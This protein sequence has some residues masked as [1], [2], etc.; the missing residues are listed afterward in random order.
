MLLLRRLPFIWLKDAGVMSSWMPFVVL[1]AMPSSLPSPVKEVSVAGV[2][3][4]RGGR[5]GG[6][7]GG[8][9][10]KGGREGGGGGGGEGD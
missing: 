3:W 9:G 8:R 4:R 1:A 5:K 7:E 6:R 10:G 2:V